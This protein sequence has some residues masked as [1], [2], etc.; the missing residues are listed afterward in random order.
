MI[1]RCALPRARRNGQ[2]SRPRVPAGRPGATASQPADGVTSFS[3]ADG[4]ADAAGPPVPR[5]APHSRRARGAFIH[6][7]RCRVPGWMSRL[8]GN[9]CPSLAGKDLHG[10]ADRPVSGRSTGCCRVA[11]CTACCRPAGSSSEPSRSAPCLS[12]SGWSRAWPPAAAG[13]QEHGQAVRHRLRGRLRAQRLRRR[14]V[15]RP[16][17]SD[18]GVPRRVRPPRPRPVQPFPAGGRQRYRHLAVDRVEF[19]RRLHG[20]RARRLGIFATSRSRS[21]ATRARC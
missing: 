6:F 3:A 8:L 7:E 9:Y 18:A 14:P 15:H 4:E 17:A 5:P 1:V 2:A 12:I 20:R 21:S 19:M 13:G 16:G 11:A 10:H